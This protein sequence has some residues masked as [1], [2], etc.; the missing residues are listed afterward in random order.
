MVDADNGFE[1]NEDKPASG[2]K[3]K[4]D[5]SRAQ[6]LKPH[7]V[8][9]VVDKWKSMKEEAAAEG[10][11]PTKASLLKWAQVE[12]QHPKLQRTQLQMMLNKEEQYRAA[13]SKSVHTT[14]RKHQGLPRP[15]GIGHHPLM[16]QEL[17]DYIQAVRQMGVPVETWM[18]RE[19]SKRIFCK[20]N[21]D[22]YPTEAHINV[23]GDEDVE[24]PLKFSGQWMTDFLERHQFLFRKLA[25]KMNKKATA[26]SSLQEIKQFHLFEFCSY[27]RSTIQSMGS[28]YQILLSLMIKFHLGLQH[29]QNRPSTQKG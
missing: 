14:E 29:K 12:L 11:E 15:T 24:Y 1:V 10:K 6:Q 18:I 22:K 26:A 3:Y 8:K 9:L 28:L 13:A 4:A 27:H 20:Q 19:E 16:E 25:T 7:Q 2:D 23:H 21:P 17:A 5:G